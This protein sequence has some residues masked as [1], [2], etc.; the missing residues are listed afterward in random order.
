MPVPTTLKIS[1]KASD[2]FWGAI[3]DDEGNQVGE[4]DGYVPDF[5]PGDHCGD[6]VE[7]EIDI[8]TGRITN[9]KRPTKKD[10]SIFE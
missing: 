8:K 5:F 9:W 2:C 7:L 3:L 1:A 10:L 6:Y 4:Y